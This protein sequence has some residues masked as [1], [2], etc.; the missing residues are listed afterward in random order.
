MLST[1]NTGGVIPGI[2][3]S[4]FLAKELGLN[5]E[6]YDQAPSLA[7]VNSPYRNLISIK[8]FTADG[9]RTMAT[10]SVVGNEPFLVSLDSYKNFPALKLEEGTVLKFRNKDQPGAMSG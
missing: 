4:P 8:A 3:N 5:M 7:S 9:Q 2:V 1:Q 6:I 10:G